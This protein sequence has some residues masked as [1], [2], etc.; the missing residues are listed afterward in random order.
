MG[1]MEHTGGWKRE[2]AAGGIVYRETDDDGVEVLLIE[3]N[4]RN[5]PEGTGSWRI[6][7]GLIEE[8]ELPE[9]AAVREVREEAGVTG[10]VEELL[11][12]IKIFYKSE[13][14]NIF[15]TV[16]CYLM[17]YV[18]GQAQADGFEVHQ[19]AWF[20]INEAMHMLSFKSERAAMGKARKILQKRASM[21]VEEPQDP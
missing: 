17:H 9:K 7:K 21:E 14:E 12:E 8:K 6:P 19:A 20:P 3:P 11:E 18:S 16:K 1:V 10:G 15:K 5:S 2:Y 4:K 13:G